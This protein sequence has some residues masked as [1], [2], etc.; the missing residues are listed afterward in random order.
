MTLISRFKDIANKYGQRV[1]LYSEEGQLT[2]YELNQKANAVA[3]LLM[4]KESGSNVIGIQMKRSFSFFVAVLGVLKSGR[5]YVPIDP[6]YPQERIDQ[7]ISGAKIDTVICESKPNNTNNVRYIELNREELLSESDIDMS[8]I[9]DLA[10]VLFTSG[11]T[12]SPNGVMITH[13]SILNTVLWV[14]DYY[15]LTP[16]DVELQVASISYTSALQDIFSTL[17][18]GGSLVLPAEE[19]M[20]NSR[21]LNM[22]T[23]KFQVTHF[24]IVPTLYNVFLDSVN[25]GNSL[26]Y[27]LVAGEKLQR[28]LVKKHFAILP[29]VRLINEYGMAETSSCCT[30]KEIL[31]PDDEITIGTPIYNTAYLIEDDDN[32]SYGE[33]LIAGEGLAKGY[34]END[35]LTEQKFVSINKARYFK[36]GDIVYK[37]EIGD[38]VYVGR[39]DKQVKINGRRVNLDE[40]DVQLQSCEM[41]TDSLTLQVEFREKLLIVS[42]LIA[43][44]IDIRLLRDK[45]Q[46]KL[47]R[48]MVPTYFELIKAFPLLP[49]GKKNVKEMKNMFIKKLEKTIVI[50][51]P[52]YK[53]ILGSIQDVSHGLLMDPAYEIDVRKQGIDSITFIQLLAELEDR[54]S[55]EFGY[56]DIDKLNVVSM[57]NLYYHISDLLE[58]KHVE[59][60]CN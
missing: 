2:Y 23:Q 54:L 27:V 22:L 21:Y 25:K 15:A 33:L 39:K 55:F 45:L 20:L 13:R 26:R 5:A 1:A 47:P 34:Y 32:T 8:L 29:G 58:K 51:T 44:N 52:V 12:G 11:S 14:I 28:T 35:K 38:L 43:L 59:N 56:D 50:Q 9:D 10:C 57:E 31:S 16:D 40:V 46:E 41:V 48:H 37:N 6:T 17:L 42:F 36:T 18:S 3:G 49:N 60:R 53:E 4:R 24:D 19:R 7:M 30:A